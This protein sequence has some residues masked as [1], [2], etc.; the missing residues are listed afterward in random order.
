MVS[1]GTLFIEKDVV[2][3]STYTTS[4][5]WSGNTVT[6]KVVKTTPHSLDEDEVETYTQNFTVSMSNLSND[7]LYAENTNFTTTSSFYPTNTSNNDG[8]WTINAKKRSFTYSLSNNDVSRNMPLEVNDAVITFDDGTFSHT[9]DISLN[10]NK[11]EKFNN[12]F[13]D[14]LYTVTPHVLTVTATTEGKSLST[15]G[16]TDIYVK[17][18]VTVKDYTKRTVV[19]D[20]GSVDFILV[21][22]MSDNT[23]QTI[24]ASSTYGSRFA[25]NFKNATPQT[26]VVTNVNHKAS[27]TTPSPTTSANNQGKWSVSVSSNTYNHILD[28]QIAKDK[29]ESPFTYSSFSAI[30]NDEDLGN[31][32]FN[33][34][35]V[36][37]SNKDFSINELGLSNGYYEYNANISVNAIVTGDEGSYSTDLGVTHLLKVK[38]TEPDGPHLGKPKS[39]Y[40]SATYDPTTKVTRRAFCFNWEDGVTYAVC[41]YETMLP[42][43]NEFKYEISSYSGFNSVGYNKNGSKWQPAR[44]SDDN[45]AIRWY[46]SNSSLIS[47]IDKAVSC[48]AIGW[49]NIV[50]DKYSLIIPGYTYTINGYEI[51][52]TAPN[53]EAVT[54]NSHYTK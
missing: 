30:Y 37:V 25:F 6:V 12:S 24:N 16:Q 50:N 48:K 7:K 54:F 17:T 11:S 9:F 49:K 46:D 40:V 45:D 43:N 15:T 31:V 8:F 22:N 32:S 53:G 51:T 13:V 21:K 52:V 44:G 38:N 3:K 41:D 18:P 4:K 42:N 5:T 19:Y 14:G 23:T 1:N 29:V 47:A 35:S 36:R 33:A 39:F 2:G 20:D 26:K 34:P 27:S 28:N 10:V